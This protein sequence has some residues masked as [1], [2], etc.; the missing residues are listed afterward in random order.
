MSKKPLAGDDPKK[1]KYS[2]LHYVKKICR[3]PTSSNF[4]TPEKC[5]AFAIN[6]MRAQEF[7]RLMMPTQNKTR[8]IFDE[9][10]A[11]YVQSKEIP[12]FTC[13]GSQEAQNKAREMFSLEKYGTPHGVKGFGELVF[14]CL[15]IVE[16]GDFWSRNV[17]YAGVDSQLYKIDGGLAFLGANTLGYCRFLTPL[18]DDVLLGKKHPIFMREYYRA[19]LKFIVLPDLLLEKFIQH[20]Q[21]GEEKISRSDYFKKI[22]DAFRKIKIEEDEGFKQYILSDDAVTDLAAYQAYLKEFKLT[23]KIKLLDQCPGA[24][25]EINHFFW[26]Y[27][28]TLAPAFTQQQDNYLSKLEKLSQQ[29]FELAAQIKELNPANKEKVPYETRIVEAIEK[30]QASNKEDQAYDSPV[31]LQNCILTLQQDLKL[32]R[33][34]KKPEKQSAAGFWGFIFPPAPPVTSASKT[35]GQKPSAHP[36]PSARQ[37]GYKG[38]GFG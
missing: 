2:H 6:E 19:R 29:A 33:S 5:K 7:L 22:R 28:K 23:G 35:A 21:V 10:G 30:D 12:G 37:Q 26:N 18:Y 20:Y 14:F 38:P 36:Q 8:L 13:L 16:D 31:A 34:Q 15:V 9:Q 24:L 32:V 17:G 4:I 27:R 1:P 11:V 3:N 25:Y